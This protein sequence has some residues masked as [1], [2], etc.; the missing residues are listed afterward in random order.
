MVSVLLYTYCDCYIAPIH[1]DARAYVHNVV[2]VLVVQNHTVT[3]SVE[4][5]VRKMSS[6]SSPTHHDLFGARTVRCQI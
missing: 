6:I 4:D 3:C 1:T 5:P 2:S